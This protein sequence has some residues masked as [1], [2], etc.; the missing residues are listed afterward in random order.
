MNIIELIAAIAEIEG[1]D[2]NQINIHEN[3]VTVTFSVD[4]I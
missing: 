3:H 4:L 2:I 1:S